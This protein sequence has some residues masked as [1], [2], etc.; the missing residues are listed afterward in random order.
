MPEPHWPIV[1]QHPADAERTRPPF[2]VASAEPPAPPAG[3]V[4]ADALTPAYSPTVYDTQE[5]RD[6]LAQVVIARLR[7]WQEGM[8][9]LRTLVDA[10][11]RLEAF[12]LP[13]QHGTP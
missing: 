7:E 11:Q 5:F 10:A 12:C 9:E 6:Q 4:T 1:E 8:D 2:V 3:D 13:H